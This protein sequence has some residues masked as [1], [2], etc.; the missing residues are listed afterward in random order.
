MIKEEFIVPSGQGKVFKVKKD[1]V[2]HII[3]VEGPQAADLVIYNQNDMRET[4]S[5]WLTRHNARNF[6]YAEKLY[7]KLPAGNVMFT[8]LNP[9]PGIF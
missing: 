7:S 3:A 5:A 4:F 2:L 9:K 6:R 8:V 1:Q